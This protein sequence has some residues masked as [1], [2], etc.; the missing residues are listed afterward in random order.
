MGRMPGARQP[1]CYYRG[2]MML[3]YDIGTSYLKGAVVTPSGKVVSR[4]QAPL[5]LRESRDPTHRESDPDDW[6]AGLAIVTAEMSLREKG[7]IRGVVVSANGP[8][9]VPVGATGE[10]LGPAMTWMD[11]R[12]AAEADLIS[13]YSDAPIDASFYLPKALWIMRHQPEVYEATRHFLACA[14]Y[15]CYFLTG[16]P[17]RIIPSPLFKEFFWNEDAIQPLSMD[18]DKFP[19]FM[20]PGEIIGTVSERAQDVV[21]IPS[22]I[23]VIAGGP[24][25]VMSILGT[26]AISTG[27]TCDRAG[28][29]EGI[30]LCWSAPVRDNRLLCFPHLAHGHYNVSAMISS[31]GS[32]LDWAARTFGRKGADYDSLWKDAQAAPAGARRLLFLPFLSPERFPIWDSRLK[33]SFLGLTTEHGR[34]EMLR[35]VV[36]STGFAVRGIIAAMESNGCRLNDLRVSGG[37]TRQPL[38]CQIRA[39][40][41]GKNVLLPEQEDSDL[42]GNACVG[43]Y[44]VEEYTSLSSACDSMVRFQ[45]TYL[46]NPD[47]LSLYDDLYGVFTAS[48][49]E[50]GETLQGL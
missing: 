37:Q 5:R 42:V 11:R 14:E 35:A 18:A 12:A 39:D 33:G 38:W 43:F 48:C 28:T 34:K 50:M 40:I 22:G 1:A 17:S 49:A 30:N 15:V 3:A 8:T 47:T 41:T 2:H 16:N 7:R 25:Y 20:E 27:R 4:A 29:S 6:L 19:P 44:A 32:A 23:P 24:D 26:A 36:E 46:P 45:R 10:P 31:S 21:G 13:E 9:L